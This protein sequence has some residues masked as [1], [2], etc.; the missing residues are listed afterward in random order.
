MPSSYKKVREW[1]AVY[2]CVGSLVAAAVAVTVAVR[3]AAQDLRARNTESGT[4]LV[5]D[6]SDA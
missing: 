1:L 4:K 5:D 2:G 3:D 6:T